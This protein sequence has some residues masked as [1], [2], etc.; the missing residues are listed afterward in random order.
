MFWAAGLGEL[1]AWVS[2]LTV[3]GIPV[4]TAVKVK[5]LLGITKESCLLVELFRFAGTVPPAG[6]VTVQRVKVKP[7]LVPASTCICEPW[8]P[9]T[10]Y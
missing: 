7:S 2:K 3:R 10:L 4:Q 8:S 5:L 9:K 6:A 1:D